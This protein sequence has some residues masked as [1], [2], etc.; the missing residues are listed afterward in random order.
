MP[1]ALITGVTGQDG[2]Y[3]GE[4]LVARGYRVAGIARRIGEVPH[5]VSLTPG[6]VRDEH[7]LRACL[8]DVRPDEVYHLAAESSVVKS[9]S[10]PDASEAAVLNGTRVLLDACRAEVPHARVVVAS[11]SEVFAATDA[12]PQNEATPLAPQSPYG[13]GKAKAVEL[14]R[15]RRASGEHLSVAILYNHESPRRST[16]FLSRKVTRGVAAIARGLATELTLGALDA[17]R[18]WGFAGDYVDA[19]WR[20]TQQPSGSD[21]VI[22]SGVSRS[23]WDL[24]ET[25]FAVVNLEAR[26]FVRSDPAIVRAVDP[27]NLVADAAKAHRLLGWV[28][29]TSFAAMIRDMVDADLARLSTQR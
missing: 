24:C 11:S 20:M 8:R 18:D 23:V 13:R 29:Q 19:L 5:G 15:S 16:D 10:D 25:A 17:Q 4:L 1:G 27:G 28:P 22:G 3:L 6:D 7:V 12:T 14:V 9:W 26:D 21:Y 2:W